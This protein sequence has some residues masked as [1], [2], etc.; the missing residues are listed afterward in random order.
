MTKMDKILM[1]GVL[2]SGLIALFL[3][4]GFHSQGQSVVAII[5][6]K[7]DIVETIDLSKVEKAKDL[8]IQ[9]AQGLSIIE[10]ENSRIRMVESPCPDRVCINRGW[11]ERSG[12][13]IVCVPNEIV[14]KIKGNDESIDD[15]TQ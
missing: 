6:V 3:V 1:L 13:A 14:I 9:G 4:K 11:I 2:L 5:Q 10:V 12:E 8:H 15:I 7:G